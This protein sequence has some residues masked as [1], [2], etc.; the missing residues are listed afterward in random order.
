MG[1]GTSVVSKL[2]NRI[3]MPDFPRCL[4]RDYIKDTI[5]LEKA[6]DNNTIRCWRIIF[7]NG[8]RQKNS[9][10]VNVHLKSIRQVALEWT[11][12]YL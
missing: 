1:R 12:V 4:L 5:A 10:N 7:E 6:Q 11:A 9:N 2:L 3:E 8:I